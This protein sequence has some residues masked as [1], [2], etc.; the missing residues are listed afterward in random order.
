[1]NQSLLPYLVIP[2]HADLA[3]C[4]WPSHSEN[5]F[6]ILGEKQKLAQK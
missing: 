4:A 3:I 6:L 5:G 2:V 1:M